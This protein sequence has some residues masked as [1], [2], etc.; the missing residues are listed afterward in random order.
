M[1]VDKSDSMKKQSANI[2]KGKQRAAKIRS[3]ALKTKAISDNE[4][5]NTLF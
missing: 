2:Y 3:M 1:A 4:E 5:T